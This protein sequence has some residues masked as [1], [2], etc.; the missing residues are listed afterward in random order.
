MIRQYLTTAFLAAAADQ[1]VK[2]II[3]LQM[4]LYS[5]FSV[6][7]GILD[8]TYIENYGIAFGLTG[9]DVSQLKRWLLCGVIFAA[10]VIIAVYW[11]KNTRGGFLFDFSI[12]LITGGAA[13]NLIDRVFRG[14]VIDFIHLGYKGISL[15]VFNIADMAVS[16]GVPLFIIYLFIKK[17]NAKEAG[18]ASHTV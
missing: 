18:N 15:P 16:A 1:L 5:S 12:G 17:E 2:F 7:P 13:G 3:K 4:K 11:A 6:I 10:I 8:I 9:Q 14:S